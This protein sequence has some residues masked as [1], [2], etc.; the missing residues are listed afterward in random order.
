[1]LHGSTDQRCLGAVGGLEDQLLPT[2]GG[3]GVD[4]SGGSPKAGP[5]PSARRGLHCAM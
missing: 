3:Y 1:M 5:A 2:P 4:T